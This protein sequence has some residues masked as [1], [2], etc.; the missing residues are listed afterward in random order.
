MA[1]RD[2]DPMRDA[3]EAQTDRVEREFD[4]ALVEREACDHSASR[5][6]EVKGFE[7]TFGWNGYGGPDGR[8]TEPL[9]VGR[10]TV[11]RNRR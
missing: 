9:V 10:A 4:H 1:P 8:G 6:P 2:W 11:P 5:R 7:D 3:R